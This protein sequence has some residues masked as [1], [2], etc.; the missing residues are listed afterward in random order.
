MARQEQDREDLLREATAYVERIELKAS[1]S[2]LP[3][4]VG[5]RAEGGASI[6]YG[7]DFVLHFNKAGE[8]R[9][10]F[11]GSQLLKAEGG[12]MIGMTRRREAREV[13]LESERFTAKES[14]EFLLEAGRSIDQL[15]DDVRASRF[16]V[17]GQVPAERDLVGRVREWLAQLPRPLIV[18]KRPNVN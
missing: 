5:F 8:L 16:K 6:Y 2:D 9:R 18:A 14:A 4:F 17:L 13:V 15:L 12:A 10:A 1:G 7:P 3:V 11:I